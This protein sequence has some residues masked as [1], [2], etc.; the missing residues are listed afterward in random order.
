MMREMRGEFLGKYELG[1]YVLFIVRAGV[2]FLNVIGLWVV[3]LNI[4]DR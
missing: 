3:V 4:R 2:L 1:R